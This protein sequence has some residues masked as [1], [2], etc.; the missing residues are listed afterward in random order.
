M[1]IV[2]VRGEDIQGAEVAWFAPL[3]SDDFRHLGIPVT[4]I[5]GT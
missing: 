1:S 5:V 2:P 3:C 4:K